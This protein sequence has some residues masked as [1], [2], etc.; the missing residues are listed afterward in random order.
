VPAESVDRQPVA[1]Q[2]GQQDQ[3]GDDEADRRDV[4]GREAGAQAE[5]GDQDPAGP[6]ADR[7]QAKK[8]ALC[9]HAR[10]ALRF[11]R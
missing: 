11:D 5:P 4:L 8:R 9:I 3:P 1:L 7:R 6:D 10:S 2:V